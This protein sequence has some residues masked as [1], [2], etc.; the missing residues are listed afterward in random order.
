MKKLRFKFIV[1]LLSGCSLLSFSQSKKL[2]MESGDK[3]FKEKDYATA[4]AYYSKVLDDTTVLQTYVLPYEIQMVNLKLKSLMKVPELKVKNL[5]YHPIG[6]KTTK[7]T[8]AK[9]DTLS[10][11]FTDPNKKTGVD[12]N[13][14]SK[15]D[16]VLF[17]L[18]QSYRLNADYANAMVVYKKLVD[19]KV[20]PDAK[21]Y[22]A[23]SLMNLKKY[24]EALVQ[25]DD[26]ISSNPAN[27]SLLTMAQKKESSCYFALDTSH[28]RRE[29]SVRMMD[30]TVFNWGTANFAPMYDLSPNKI[31]F[32][33]ARKGGVVTNPEKQDSKYLCDLYWTELR[34]SVWSKPVNFGRPVNSALHEGA[35]YVTPDEVMLFT[36][37]SDN[38]RDEAFIYMAKMQD[39]AFFDAFKLNE[40]VNLAGYKSMQPFV[41]FDGT[42]LFYSSNRPGGKGGFDIWMCN[43]DENGFIGTP[44]NLGS[45]INT[46]GD[47]VSPFFHAVSN[48]LFFSSNGMP[49][50]GGLDIFKAA[51]NVDDS[52]Y[53]MPKNVGLPINSSQDDAYFIMERM[54]GRGFFASDRAECEGGHCY[55]IYE[56]MNEPIKF[57][58]SGYVF[59]QQTNEPMP[60]ALITIKDVHNDEE[61]F[62]VVSDDKGYYFSELKPNMEYFLKAQKTKYFGDAA[63]WAT[64]G[65]TETNHHEQD[66]FLNKIPA[67]EIEIAGIE[68]DFDKATLRASSKENLDKIVELLKLND[69]LSV[70]I[71]SHT[72][73]RG[74]DA[75]NMKLSQARAQS[76]VDYLHSKGIGFKR[77]HAKGYGETDPIIKEAD[78]NKMVAK[79]PEWEAAHQ[80]NRR[81]AFKVVGESKIEIRT[82]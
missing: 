74:N 34:D 18:A 55:N 72:D 35:G 14:I 16:Y 64:K 58:I 9:K 81:T 61:P 30:T 69:N 67:G 50:L 40:N 78:I 3:A 73:C 21:Y 38:N 54:Q 42:K 31:I 51:F 41:N 11:R 59:D 5:I 15:Y 60:G 77:L 37:W 71:N 13:E 47:E 63:G 27:D 23:I 70:D 19:K 45:P 62:F 8:T 53:A 75:Y 48:T 66:F 25:F 39:G 33:S 68:Y 65:L 57:D 29:I 4:A 1:L 24:N 80:K 17:Q 49:G 36:R 46:T 76:C 28:V 2:W 56:F 7:D 32:T 82:K 20:F 44:K 12:L 26:Y 79:S 52:I 43:I 6:E 22:Y 10:A